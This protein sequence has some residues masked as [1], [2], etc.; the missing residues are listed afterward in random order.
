MIRNFKIWGLEL[1]SLAVRFCFWGFGSAVSHRTV[2][3]FS[4]RVVQQLR[5]I[6]VAEEGSS[7]QQW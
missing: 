6:I 4:S 7:L 2:P 5:R 1:E 3:A